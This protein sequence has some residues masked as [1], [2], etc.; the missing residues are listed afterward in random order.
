MASKYTNIL[1][2]T[3]N[4]GSIFEDVSACLLAVLLVV[5]VVWWLSRQ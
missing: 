4:V 3:A 2:V 5:V 1:L